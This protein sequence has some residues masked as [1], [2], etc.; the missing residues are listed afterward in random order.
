LA[1]VSVPTRDSSAQGQSMSSVVETTTKDGNGRCV[2]LASLDLR[3]AQISRQRIEAMET[4]RS[5]ESSEASSELSDPQ[6]RQGVVEKDDSAPCQDCNLLP[7]PEH[8]NRRNPGHWHV[9]Y[10]WWYCGPDCG[11]DCCGSMP[12]TQSR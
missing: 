1:Q 4:D 2:S 12:K 8:R 10:H 3:A 5:R 9:K 7:S 11:P 6:Q